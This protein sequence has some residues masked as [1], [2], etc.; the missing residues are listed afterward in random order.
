MFLAI[1]LF[2]FF[3]Y[4]NRKKILKRIYNS[5]NPGGALI[6][7]DKVRSKNAQFEDIFTQ[8]Y[9]DYKLEM[10]L[11]EKEII[12]KSK[13][14]RSSMHVFDQEQIEKLFIK[15]NYKRFDVFFKCFNFVGYIVTK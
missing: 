15:C 5:L 3:N 13:S 2:P 8:L 10:K 4:N 9:F 1:L 6:I 11:T 14:L 12:K 7:M